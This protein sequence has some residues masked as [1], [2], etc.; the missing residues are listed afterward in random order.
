MDI[1]FLA[2]CKDLS[3]GL[4]VITAYAEGLRMLGHNVTV[5][6]PR[7]ALSPRQRLRRLRDDL[8]EGF[9]DRHHLVRFGGRVVDVPDLSA[10][11][12]PR[13][14]IL[15]ATAY[16][17][18]GPVA[19]ACAHG[20]QGFYLIQGYETFSGVEQEVIATYRL[21]LRK[22][23]VS[24]WLAL[25]VQHRS[26]QP[27][28][29][30]PNASD[31]APMSPDEGAH[32]PFDIGCFYSSVTGKNGALAVE[33]LKRLRARRGKLEAVVI[34][35]E[36]RPVELPEW[37]R[38]VRCPDQDQLRALYLRTKVW[39]V[40]S[41][42]EGFCLP[43]LE[44]MG[45]GCAVVAY[46][47]RGVHETIQSSRNG[48]IVPFGQPEQFMTRVEDLLDDPWL[49]R[50][51]ARAARERAVDFSWTASVTAMEAIFRRELM[52]QEFARERI[53]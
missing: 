43:A 27:C 1:N 22:I 2:P 18:A 39:S 5:V 30:I 44:A 21:P 34:G 37:A 46:D 42:E 53:A 14:D 13:G 3:G 24:R 12:I 32:R 45:L 15:V 10:K 35:T 36:P 19:E 31:F 17:T 38:Y 23:A 50:R 7:R 8:R 49:H 4:R 20:A 11:Y 52:L 9:P 6:V 33:T 47:N 16:R 40:F 26:G 41:S 51:I 28:R 29:V 48:Y 25:A